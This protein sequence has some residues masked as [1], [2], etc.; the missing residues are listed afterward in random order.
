MAEREDEAPH[1]KMD[2]NVYLV[3]FGRL[4]CD[5]KRLL[6]EPIR[7]NHPFS[8][9]SREREIEIDIDITDREREREK[10]ESHSPIQVLENQESI[11]I[12]YFFL[13]VM[14]CDVVF[15]RGNNVLFV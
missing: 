1:M 9:S 12:N 5:P 2:E 6:L 7:L 13:F 14:F 3:R 4:G 15:S 10:M 11:F 8:S